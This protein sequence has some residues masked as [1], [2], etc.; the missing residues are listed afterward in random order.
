MHQHSRLG[1][2]PSLLQIYRSQP[3]HKNEV[4]AAQQAS[5]ILVS[6]QRLTQ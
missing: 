1:M 4:S 3:E 6:I 5:T 2:G